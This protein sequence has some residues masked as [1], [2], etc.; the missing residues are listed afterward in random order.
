MSFVPVVDAGSFAAMR[1]A[2]AR[3]DPNALEE[4][5]VHF[6]AL[7]VGM[8]LKSA[9]S[10]SLGDGLLDGGDTRQYLEL[11]DAQVALDVARQGGLGFGRMLVEQLGGAQSAAARSPSAEGF[12]V[13]ERS[14]VARARLAP[15]SSASSPLAANS[16]GTQRADA[17][18]G[19]RST[20]ADSVNAALPASP[21]QSVTG[22]S[23]DKSDAREHF[24]RTLLPHAERAAKRLG[25]DPKLL[26]AQAALE[27]GWGASVPRRADGR[28]TNN[29]FGMKAGGSWRGPKAG[30]WT[31]EIVAGMP[32]RRRADFRA[33]ESIAESFSDYANVI[34]GLPRYAEAREGAADAE[35]Y[36]RALADAGYA[37]DPAYAEKWLAVYRSAPIAEATVTGFAHAAQERPASADNARATATQSGSSAGGAGAAAKEDPSR[38]HGLTARMD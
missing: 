9:R 14:A 33:Y 36:A 28:S 17:G 35:T 16:A 18:T 6:E 3:G 38:F 26:V 13:P 8:L 2:A 5:A 4:A 23:D 29:L 7:F 21:A 27:T 10:A 37:T 34:E 24:V 1:S 22:S 32:E 15:E 20:A 25:V 12:A 30:A 19:A 31:L 11:M